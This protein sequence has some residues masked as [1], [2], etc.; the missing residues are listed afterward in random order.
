[1][2]NNS[3][4]FCV[5]FSG[6]SMLFHS[7]LIDKFFSWIWGILGVALIF[8]SDEHILVD[9]GGYFEAF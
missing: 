9:Y 6:F 8:W 1:M 2:N 4:L 7:C 3:L 5:R